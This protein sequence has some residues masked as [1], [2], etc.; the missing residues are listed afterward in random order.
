MRTLRRLLSEKRI[1]AM[2]RTVRTDAD[3]HPQLSQLG[4][5]DLDE[6]GR[7]RVAIRCKVAQS[8]GDQITAR[9]SCEH[10]GIHGTDY[11]LTNNVLRRRRSAGDHFIS[12]AR[13]IAACDSVKN[14]SCRDVASTDSRMIP[15]SEWLLNGSSTWPTSCAST[16][17]N[18]ALYGMPE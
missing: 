5:A 12:R 6:E 13:I 16:R 10:I 9:Q 2:L 1:E 7:D 4:G 18:R 17:P 11:R 15:V 8:L 3:R 14:S